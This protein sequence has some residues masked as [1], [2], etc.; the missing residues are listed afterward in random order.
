VSGAGAPVGR[1]AGVPAEP[2]GAA[3]HEGARGRGGGEWSA[4]PPEAQV[5]GLGGGPTEGSAR[6]T[7]EGGGP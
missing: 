5:G 1:G 2:V 6:A 4:P 3:I 7:T